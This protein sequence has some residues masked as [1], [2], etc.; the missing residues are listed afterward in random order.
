MEVVAYAAGRKK[1]VHFVKE[2]VMLCYCL[3]RVCK[4][5]CLTERKRSL[6]EGR[7]GSRHRN[8]VWSSRP[9]RVLHH[10]TFPLFHQATHTTIHHSETRT[11]GVAEQTQVFFSFFFFGLKY[12]QKFWLQLSVDFFDIYFFFFHEGRNVARA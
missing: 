7:S 4:H 8:R 5:N 6:M 10:Q 2:S 12:H 9:Q 3:V 11:A 1:N